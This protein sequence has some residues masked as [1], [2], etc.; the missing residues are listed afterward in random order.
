MIL[1]VQDNPEL[2]RKLG[3]VTAPQLHEGQREDVTITFM[4][5]S[6]TENFDPERDETAIA[7]FTLRNARFYC[8]NFILRQMSPDQVVEA[9]YNIHTVIHTGESY[10]VVESNGFQRLYEYIFTLEAERRGFP[11]P[12]TKIVRTGNKELR[13]QSLQIWLKFCRWQKG[14]SDQN[15]VIEQGRKYRLGVKNQRDD[16]LDA[17]QG[18]IVELSQLSALAGW[19][20]AT[21]AA[22]VQ[23]KTLQLAQASASVH[24]QAQINAV[25]RSPIVVN[26]AFYMLR[27]MKGF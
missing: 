1:H 3:I 12:I 14:Q 13:I 23:D 25:P 9:F 18:C 10:F 24:P 17:T 7:T 21:H 20:A 8:R 22:S 16:A 6:A 4:D 5:P 2:L 11:L 19:G 15:K 27:K 26:Q